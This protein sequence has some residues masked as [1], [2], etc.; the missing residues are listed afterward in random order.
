MLETQL[1]KYQS[2]W[3]ASSTASTRHS[4]W[5]HYLKF[6]ELLELEPLPAS[7]YA[8]LMYVSYMATSFKYSSIQNYLSALWILHKLA[9]F[10]HI[11]PHTFELQI[12]LR[13]V[14]R[15]LGD[16]VTQARPISVTELLLIH[17]HLDM[18]N[19]EDLAFWLVMII[20]FRGLLRKSNLVEKE[21]CL[22]VGD[23]YF[24]QWGVLFRLRRTKTIQFKE[25][26]LDIPFCYL[27]GSPFCVG[28]YLR[29]LLAMVNHH[30]RSQLICYNS[31]TR[32]VR[33]SYSWLSMRI[34]RM[35]K[36]L[37]LMS[38]SSHSLRRGG[39]SAMSDAGFSLLDIKNL[40]DWQSL[41][42]LQYLSK[43]PTAKLD[44]DH[45]VAAKLFLP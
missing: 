43:S 32:V 17:S 33:A 25:R 10:S 40:G 22:L 30:E 4:Q 16:V 31:S 11:D 5:R 44:L 39:A 12:T 42:V 2:N 35:V 7:L 37:G 18:S 45:R 34:N 9:G 23:V 36:A 29:Q 3:M 14:R 6:C 41:S 13:G 38:F 28:S 20:C 19:S 15:S 27:P 26:T 21:L 24:F 8:V 1:T